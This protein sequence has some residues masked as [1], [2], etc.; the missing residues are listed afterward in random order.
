MTAAVSQFFLSALVILL[1]GIYLTRS[2]DIIGER[3]KIGRLIAGSILLASATSLPEFLVDLTAI[4]NNLPDLAIGDLIGSSLFNLMILAVADLIHKAPDKM[5]SKRYVRHSLSALASINVTAI[6][7]FGLFT[8]SHFTR[9]EYSSF[10][11][12]DIM[13]F[14]LVVIYLI[15]LRIILRDQQS[16]ASLI[17]ELPVQEGQENQEN[18]GL[19]RAIVT[20]I[21][22]GFALLL[23]APYITEAAEEIAKRTG[24][25]TTF[26]GT[27]LVGLTTSL[28]EMVSTI[29]AVRMGA[30]DL[31]LGNIFGSNAFNM[32]LIF[33]L[34]FFFNGSLLAS[35]S[36][37]HIVTCLAAILATSVA[38][39]GQLYQVESRRR[40]LDPDAFSVILIV[41]AAIGLLYYLG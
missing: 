30:F 41:L 1:A 18:N 33:P 2:A 9:L 22:S 38:A 26:I 34:D 25:G 27:T 39:M 40:F 6:A 14:F 12:I 23:A 11:G 7:A 17:D 36:P 10:A 32:I 21:T 28:P 20:Y 19:G 29:T 15:S 24:A 8:A 16:T 35:A 4:R 37:L 3:T 13:L 5:I 31:A